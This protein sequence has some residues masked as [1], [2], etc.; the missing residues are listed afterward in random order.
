MGSS[1]FEYEPLPSRRS[2]RLVTLVRDEIS[3]FGFRCQLSVVSLDSSP[4]FNALSYTWNHLYDP[5]PLGPI[6][7]LRAW[8]SALESPPKRRFRV[9]VDADRY[10]NVNENLFSALHQFSRDSLDN[11]QAITP[12]H[13]PIWIDEI[14]INQADVAERSS[15]VSQ[16]ADI[17]ATAQR[18]IVW[19]GKEKLDPDFLW[20]HN[21]PA[22]FGHLYLQREPGLSYPKS[23]PVSEHTIRMLDITSRERW[24][25]AWSAYVRFFRRNGYFRRLW[26]VQETALAREIVVR[27]GS[28]VGPKWSLMLK[29]ASLLGETGWAI[30]LGQLG[31]GM[32]QFEERWQI[33][34]PLRGSPVGGE[35]KRL[36][37]FARHVAAQSQSRLGRNDFKRLA[38]L[39]D[40]SKTPIQRNHSHL[41]FL[42]LHFRDCEATVKKDY[43]FAAAGLLSRVSEGDGSPIIVPDYSKTVHV[44][45]VFTAASAALLTNL[46]NLSLLS[47][48]EDKSKRTM[49]KMPSWV[50][51]FS[52]THSIRPL[53]WRGADGRVASNSIPCIGKTC[54]LYNAS[55]TGGVEGESFP[56]PEVLG[57]R[58][59]VSGFEVDTI[60]SV[61]PYPDISY[62]DNSREDYGYHHLAHPHFLRFC[63]KMKR[64]YAATGQPREEVLW[65]T[66]IGDFHEDIAQYPAPAGLRKD[67]R[68]MILQD[69]AGGLFNLITTEE[70]TSRTALD[71]LN[72]ANMVLVPW[73]SSSLSALEDLSF[74]DEL[75]ESVNGSSS[76]PSLQEIINKVQRIHTTMIEPILSGGGGPTTD[77][78]LA[79]AAASVELENFGK[80]MNLVAST[81]RLY[82]TSR[83]Y[84]GLGPLSSQAGDKVW[85]LMGAQVPFVLRQHGEGRFALI[86]ESYLHGFVHGQLLTDPIK[87]EISR[88][89]LV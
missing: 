10:L 14:S 84:L 29:L 88:I 82:L 49:S 64:T 58:L 48:V 87:G 60:S 68:T 74:I 7:E 78:L 24:V 50:A 80:V 81:R 54:L 71:T 47:F 42:M 75:S 45:D 38:K 36:A 63:A 37:A 35:M 9:P 67:F 51:D 70:F 32:M 43:I 15:Q 39:V 5:D 85:C 89:T 57:S 26:I 22:L 55:K 52:F 25:K 1:L 86:G 44:E 11:A 79:A 62:L 73:T 8:Q 4:I 61:C 13:T 12:F 66:L 69:I 6:D 56:P 33:S 30:E 17:Y 16:M 72:P 18:V 28:E 65:R 76:V 59:I 2:I 77:G 46:P 34:G 53:V 3:R 21:M 83:G 40:G 20:L 19:L 41:S 27:C 31:I 23:G